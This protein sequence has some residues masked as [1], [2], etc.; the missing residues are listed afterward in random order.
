MHGGL[1]LAELVVLLA[2]AAAGAALFERLRLPSIAGFLVAGALVGPGGLGLVSDP[3][4]VRAVAEGGVVFLLFEIG[5]ELPV[6]R[7]RRLLRTGVAAGA[8]QVSATLAATAAI[9]Y[10]FGIAGRSALVLGALVAMSSTALVVRLLSE[11]SEL[12]APHGQLAVA[13]LLFQD[14]CI[15]PFLLA[16][17]LLASEAPLGF[18]PIAGAL[19]RAAFLGFAFYAVTRFALPRVLSAAAGL[20]SREVFSLVAVLVVAG[21]ALGAEGL[22]LGLAVGAF[23]AGLAA[24]ASPWGHQ[25]FAEVLPLRGVLLGVFFTA[26][27]M[28]LDV[29]LAWQ[30]A[31]LVAALFAAATL[32]KAAVVAGALGGVLRFGRRISVLAALALAQTGEFSFVL[33]AAATGAGLLDG[34]LSQAFVA[35]SVLS[36]VATPF[37]LRAGPA[38]LDERSRRFAASE[39]EAAHGLSG[40]VV[41]IGY[42]LAGRNLSRVLHAVGIPWLAVDANPSSAVEAQAR[43]E[44]RVIYGDATRPALLERLGVG[45]ARIVVV[46]ITDPLATRRIV[47][48]VHRLNPSAKLI[49]RTRY[50]RDVDTLQ[51]LGASVV[52]AEELEAAIDLLG[53]VLREFGLPSAAVASFVDEL[54]D[55]GYALL[56]TPSGVALDPWL[57]ELL[58]Q[59]A[60]EWVDVPAAFP[61]GQTLG[62]LALRT[63]TGASILAV[64]RGGVTTPN[65]AAAFALRAGDRLL[66]FG[67]NP[68]IARVREVLAGAV[69]Q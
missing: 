32:L 38:L 35:A 28:L 37:V 59:V 16:V 51:S 13:I 22:G 2:L 19:A 10:A 54:R 64:E 24:S 9:A 25:L 7:L 36:L 4:A 29:K 43:D 69:A 1:P 33:L 68:E 14:L 12:D 47:S 30:H 3:E 21:A 66:V 65:P 46:A 41:V 44:S 15:V 5:L 27:G 20:R 39:A 63:R 42:G 48:L 58:Q 8:L 49:A 31:G 55:E 26:V 18:A 34:E 50:V 56:Q 6:E 40:H 11:R 45:S 67:G 17:P 57:T 62:Q 60:T 52:V 23:L 53:H 61:P